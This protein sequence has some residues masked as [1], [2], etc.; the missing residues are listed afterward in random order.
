MENKNPFIQ[1][2]TVPS[3]T[4]RGLVHVST[5]TYFV[6]RVV[7]PAVIILIPIGSVKVSVGI[8]AQ[9]A[10]VDDVQLIL[11]VED[12]PALAGQSGHAEPAEGPGQSRRLLLSK[13][14]RPPVASHLH[15]DEGVRNRRIETF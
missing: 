4:H 15:S 12:A 3:R 2:V 6:L 10:F 8:R 11:A 5:L 14:G 7:H 9:V 1:A 13:R